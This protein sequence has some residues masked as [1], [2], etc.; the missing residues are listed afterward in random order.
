MHF[1]REGQIPVAENDKLAE[2]TEVIIQQT[3][4]CEG[5]S[6][7]VTPPATPSADRH[8]FYHSGRPQWNEIFNE[9]RVQF[10]L[11]QMAVATCGPKS[12]IAELRDQCSNRSGFDFHE[13]TF[14][15]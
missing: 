11:G 10:P 4:A 8:S 15:F 9:M 2:P 1:T 14:D 5:P 12:M 13:E 3:E 6:D 7:I